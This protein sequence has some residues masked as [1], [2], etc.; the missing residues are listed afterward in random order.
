MQE[1]SMGFIGPKEMQQIAFHVFFRIHHLLL[2]NITGAPVCV[3]ASRSPTSGGT[4]CHSLAILPYGARTSFTKSAR[5]TGGSSS[6]STNRCCAGVSTAGGIE[7]RTQW[8][9]S[10]PERPSHRFAR[11]AICTLYESQYSSPKIYPQQCFAP[12]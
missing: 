3:V 9:A 6:W 5:D 4:L 2:Y 10:A 8:S 1:Q 11:T 7:R 12:H